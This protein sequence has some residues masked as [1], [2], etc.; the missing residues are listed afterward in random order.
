M[1]TWTLVTAALLAG[2][3]GTPASDVFYTGPVNYDALDR[4]P[5]TAKTKVFVKRGYSCNYK[6]KAGESGALVALLVP[7]LVEKLVDVGFDKVK[8]YNAYL[9][10]DVTLKGTS[11]LAYEKLPAAWPLSEEGDRKALDKQQF[12]EGEMAKVAA[13]YLQQNKKHSI[14]DAQFKALEVDKR[15]RFANTFDKTNVALL[16]ASPNDLCV[17]LVAGNYRSDTSTAALDEFVRREGA[18]AE[19]LRAYQSKVPTI[20]SADVDFP[21]KGLVGA[22]SLVYEA[23]LVVSPDSEVN[24]FAVV[25]QNL[26]YPNALHQG[27]VNKTERKLTI[28][29]T[30]GSHIQP[31]ELQHIKA[32]AVYSTGDIS[33]AWVMFTAP[34]NE[35]FQQISLSVSEGPDKMITSAML[36]AIETQR[37]AVK[38][39][40]KD[41]ADER[42]GNTKEE[43]K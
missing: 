39:K 1:K 33:N 9:N 30:L 36:E 18:S 35:A 7:T 34:K 37:E 17:L 5:I 20:E 16:Q 6:A 40:V 41:A 8:E 14:E 23:H 25:P 10:A 29:T 2:C 21:F 19:Q 22:P 12:I 26:F 42:V 31:L 11:L 4:H 38:K 27:V 43:G 24:T 3:S 13:G 32:G 28:I 15:E